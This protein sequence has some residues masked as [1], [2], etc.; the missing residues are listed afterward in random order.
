MLWGIRDGKLSAGWQSAVDGPAGIEPSPIFLH[1]Y[2][3]CGRMASFLVD[4]DSC[5]R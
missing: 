4:Y 5:D 2:I 1:M 3:R